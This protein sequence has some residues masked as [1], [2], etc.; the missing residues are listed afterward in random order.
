MGASLTELIHRMALASAG[1]LASGALGFPALQAAPVHQKGELTGGA[2]V[3]LSKRFAAFKFLCVHTQ[4]H[5]GALRS[6][7]RYL[8]F[9]WCMLHGVTLCLVT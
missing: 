9:G 6:F 4:P 8:A 1:R 5:H 3:G 7:G 2:G